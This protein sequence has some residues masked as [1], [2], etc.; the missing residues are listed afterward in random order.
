MNIILTPKNDV[1]LEKI[2]GYEFEGRVI[3]LKPIPFNRS[4]YAVELP[5][6]LSPSSKMVL[7]VKVNDDPDFDYKLIEK[8]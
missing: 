8:E 3:S 6:R 2:K 5:N 1:A 4:F 7:Y